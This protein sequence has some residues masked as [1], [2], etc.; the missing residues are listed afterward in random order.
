MERNDSP[1]ED[2]IS[3]FSET[4]QHWE[5]KHSK[6]IDIFKRGKNFNIIRIHA[7]FIWNFVECSINI[8]RAHDNMYN[9][10]I[11]IMVITKQVN[12]IFIHLMGR[13]F[14]LYFI[15]CDC[16]ISKVPT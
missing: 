14:N 10:I 4:V 12:L 2:K 5:E 15:M 6:P 9:Y 11:V 7:Y 3:N 13:L 1:S 8:L 16:P